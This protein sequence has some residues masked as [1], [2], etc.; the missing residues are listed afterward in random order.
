MGKL[1]Y[2]VR[3]QIKQLR[4]N[5]FSCKEIA[6]KLYIGLSTAKKY[7]NNFV[8]NEMGLLRKKEKLL[9]RSQCVRK[10]WKDKYTEK[11]KEAQ[12]IAGMI[13][14]NIDEDVNFCKIVCALLF[15]CEGNKEHRI[16]MRITNS[17]PEFIK[18]FLRFFRKS[19]VL[20][21]SKFRCLVHL[22]SHQNEDKLKAFWSNT[23]R[24]PQNQFLKSY[25]KTNANKIKK[26]NYY[27]C[28]SLRYNDS[29]IARELRA[30]YM[31]FS[32]N[33]IKIGA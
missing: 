12:L 24:I 16:G 29:S 21:E 18:I 10:R 30:L 11:E 5:G 17:D 20:D 22:H 32:S 4:E 31:A 26:P 14:K 23:T 27:G 8:L 15:W 2:S 19:F 7:G 33:E 28:L 1:N 13:I 9:D 25:F 6:D 3:E